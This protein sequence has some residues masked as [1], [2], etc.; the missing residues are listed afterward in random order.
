MVYDSISLLPFSKRLPSGLYMQP[1][2]S[3]T[4]LAISSSVTFVLYLLFVSII[5]FVYVYLI[6]YILNKRCVY[7]L[8]CIVSQINNNNCYTLCY[9]AKYVK[10][11]DIYKQRTKVFLLRYRFADLGFAV[12]TQTTSPRDYKT[13]SGCRGCFVVA[14]QTTRQQVYKWLP[15][16][17]LSR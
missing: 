11:P 16:H 2:S 9:C 5:L 7:L 13:T 17:S 1:Y 8:F 15:P 6:F 12:A 10:F 14:S 3:F 4:P